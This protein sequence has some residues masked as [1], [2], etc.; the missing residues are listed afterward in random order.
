MRKIFAGTLVLVAFLGATS[1]I[2][3]GQIQI[4]AAVDAPRGR[5]VFET[6]LVVDVRPLAAE[7]L[8]DGKVLG[9]GATLLTQAISVAP[10]RHT[11]EARAPGYHDYLGRFTADTQST[12]NRFWIVLVP[13]RR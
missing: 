7:I 2:C 13:D 4:G 3:R 12:V 11:V 6:T 10:G 8:L 1:A 5:Q 9:S